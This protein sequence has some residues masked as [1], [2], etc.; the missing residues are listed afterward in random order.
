[1]LVFGIQKAS[2]TFSGI[3]QYFIF[4]PYVSAKTYLLAGHSAVADFAA[5]RSEWGFGLFEIFV[6][7]SRL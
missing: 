6:S 5:A 7:V 2:P 1:M 4:L 3:F